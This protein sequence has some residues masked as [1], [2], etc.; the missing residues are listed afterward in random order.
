MIAFL[1]ELPNR[2][3]F[4]T[5]KQEFYRNNLVSFLDHGKLRGYKKSHFGGKCIRK[6]NK[7]KKMCISYFQEHQITEL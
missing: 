1:F 6:E 3:R 5:L 4:G 2:L 7:N